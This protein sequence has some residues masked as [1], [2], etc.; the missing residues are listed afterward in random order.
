MDVLL[1]SRRYKLGLTISKL[2]EVFTKM[3]LPAPFRAGHVL[4][5]SKH[6]LTTL[7]HNIFPFSFDCRAW[8]MFQCWLDLVSRQHHI[9]VPAASELS[10]EPLTR[11]LYRSESLIPWWRNITILSFRWLYTWKVMYGY[12]IP[13]LLMDALWHFKFWMR[14]ISVDIFSSWISSPSTRNDH[15]SGFQVLQ[16]CILQSSI[17]SVTEHFLF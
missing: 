14:T 17:S 12:Y 1:P 3:S 15:K 2:R 13:F 9:I 8:Q 4:Y 11:L 16:C 10:V 6:E 5:Y 7:I